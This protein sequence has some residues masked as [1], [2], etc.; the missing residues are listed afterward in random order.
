MYCEKLIKR[1]QDVLLEAMPSLDHEELTHLWYISNRA[2]FG[3]YRELIEKMLEKMCALVSGMQIRELCLLVRGFDHFKEIQDYE[4]V[5]RGI[6]E[7]IQKK[8]GNNRQYQKEI[9]KQIFKKLDNRKKK[10]E[11]V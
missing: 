5:C 11:I 8:L 7:K 6:L 1:L 9:V 4:D 3:I 2:K 10:V